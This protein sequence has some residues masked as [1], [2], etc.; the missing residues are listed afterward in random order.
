MKLTLAEP[1]L[2]KDSISIIADLVTEA[3]FKINPDCLELIAMDPASVAMVTFKLLSSSFEEYDVKEEQ[4]IG[5]NLNNLKQ[6]LRRATNC[7]ITLE[8]TESHMKLLMK[9][10]STKNFMI[11]L[12][13]LE[14]SEKKIPSLDFKATVVTESSILSEVVEDM[15]IVGE[16]VS[17]E[18]ENNALKVSSK[19]DLSKADVDISSDEQ[20]KI[21]AD[22]K[23]K[24]KYSIEYLKKMIQGSKLAPQVTMQFANDYPMRLEYKVLNK[25]QLAFILAPRVDND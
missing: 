16:S 1:R 5:V 4:V 19:G 18:V 13:D 25:L 3:Q 23:Y 7:S 8:F 12:I 14:D 10:K 15:D 20:T 22:E 2:L 17:F 21:V 9:G 24:S 11:P 6:V